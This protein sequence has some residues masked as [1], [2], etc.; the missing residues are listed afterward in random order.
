MQDGLNTQYLWCCKLKLPAWTRCSS[1]QSGDFT[2]RWW[3][4]EDHS[5]FL[6][7]KCTCFDN[8]IHHQDLVLIQVLP[9]W[10]CVPCGGEDLGHAWPGPPGGEARHVLHHGPVWFVCARPYPAA[11]LLLLLYSQKSFPLY[12]RAAAGSCHRTG[13]I[14]QVRGER[15]YSIF[16]QRRCS[17]A[18]FLYIL[19]LKISIALD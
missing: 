6:L 15:F 16:Q 1:F 18:L 4:N 3:E 19:M 12:Q 9:L 14:I 2:F 11:P 8:S 17:S 5:L 10:H 13:H 7:C